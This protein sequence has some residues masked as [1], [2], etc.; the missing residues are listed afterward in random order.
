MF[1]YSMIKNEVFI[2]EKFIGLMIKPISKSI[3]ALL[4]LELIKM[5]LSSIK[6]LKKEKKKKKYHIFPPRRFYPHV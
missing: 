3:P 6:I 4:K 5:N 2:S 1:A